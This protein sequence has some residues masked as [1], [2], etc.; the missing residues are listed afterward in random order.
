MNSSFFPNPFSPVP[1]SRMAQIQQEAEWL[2][3][4]HGL[5]QK[6]WRFKFDH[7][8]RRAGWC[9]FDKK[10][11]SMAKAFAIKAPD[12]E[13]HDTIL[14]EIAHALVGP[15]HQHDAVW[16]AKALEIGSQAKRCHEVEF[17]E[18]PYIKTC[19][20]GCWQQP[21]FRRN[22]RIY[23]YRCR[24]CSGKVIYLPKNSFSSAKSNGYRA[25]DGVF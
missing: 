6:G 12:A 22:R 23:Q 24:Q 8:K 10:I 14:H 13:I 21:V 19:A 17:S 16:K 5:W 11:V 25:K 15:K 7:A 18:A 3:Y 20:N 1:Q 4:Q 9:G 2:L